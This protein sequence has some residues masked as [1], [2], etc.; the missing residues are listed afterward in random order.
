MPRKHNDNPTAPESEQETRE[1]S[2]AEAAAAP[3]KSI[4]KAKAK[5]KAKGKG[6]ANPAPEVHRYERVEGSPEREKARRSLEKSYGNAE[7]REEA[8]LALQKLM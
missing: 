2:N 7:R 1:V 8:R 3:K 4:K 5:K 6:A